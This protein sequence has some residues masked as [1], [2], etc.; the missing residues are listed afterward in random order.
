MVESADAGGWVSADALQPYES[1]VFVVG[2][3]STRAVERALV[4]AADAGW[5]KLPSQLTSKLVGSEWA[6]YDHVAFSDKQALSKALMALPGAVAS[7][8]RL[9]ATARPRLINGLPL[10]RGIARNVYLAGGE[11]DL[12]LPVG[13]GR[14]DV[15]VTLD[16]VE[17]RLRASIFPFPLSSLGGGHTEGVHT[18]EAD[19]EALTF[20]VAPASADDRVPPGACSLGWV[21]GALGATSGG[22]AIVGG[23]AGPVLPDR[24]VLARRGSAE[25]WLIHYDG[26]L[27]RLAEPAPPL[28]LADLR[29]PFFEVDRDRAAWLAQRRTAGWAVARLHPPEPDFHVLGAEE[30]LLWAELVASVTSSDADWALYCRAW[31]RFDGR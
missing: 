20:V 30:R 4:T 6:I 16:G 9:G 18:V 25:T 7:S 29:F 10:L 31:E 5:R 28:Q 21:D 23:M 3:E 2:A 11:P 27:T 15:T 22:D 8:M 19:G 17:G 1:H 13:D 14:R 24:P 26:R 12:L